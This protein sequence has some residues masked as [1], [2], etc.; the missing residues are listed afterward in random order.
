LL[1]A[2]KCISNPALRH[3]DL[4][5]NEF[6]TQGNE[7]QTQNQKIHRR[8]GPKP[9][10]TF[11]FP[12]L[13]AEDAKKY[14]HNVQVDA[15]SVQ[16]LSELRDLNGANLRS[17]PTTSLRRYR[18]NKKFQDLGA[19]DLTCF[20][21]AIVEV[22][23]YEA[24]KKRN[25]EK[26]CYCQ[27]ANASAE[28]LVLRE[29]LES[30]AK[31]TGHNHVIFSFT[32]VG[33]NAKLWVTYRDKEIANLNGASSHPVDNSS[34]RPG[35]IVMRC[36]WASSLELT[37]GV[38]YIRMIVQN[39]RD[40]VYKGTKYDIARWVMKAHQESQLLRVDDHGTGRRRQ[41]VSC[42]SITRAPITHPR[43]PPPRPS[44]RS[45]PA[46]LERPRDEIVSPLSSRSRNGSSKDGFIDDSGIDLEDSD[47]EYIG[48]VSTTHLQKP[49][50]NPRRLSG[51]IS[52]REYDHSDSERE[53][54]SDEEEAAFSGCEKPSFDEY[55][56]DCSDGE[57]ITM[58]VPRTGKSIVTDGLRRKDKNESRRKSSKF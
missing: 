55:H 32:F 49:K 31:D 10:L 4:Q 52:Y 43:R 57:R 12:I 45:A 58:R 26:F 13:D 38:L 23:K 2:C 20:P 42:G 7:N 15:F 18:R 3:H 28:A 11:A 1:Y 9:D 35:R 47:D 36:I 53:G 33:P 8:T 30:K 56:Y 25:H 22:K 48:R 16:V 34:Q 6:P 5:W 27:A 24:G 51:P 41:T 14:R 54:Q 29:E 40:W 44:P 21:W 17:A 37:W 50:R 39:M 19:A 46:N